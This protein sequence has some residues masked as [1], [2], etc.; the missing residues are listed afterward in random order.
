MQ[1]QVYVT[2][3]LVCVA[4]CMLAVCMLL[5]VHAINYDGVMLYNAAVID[6][7]LLHDTLAIA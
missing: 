5:R 3:I 7:D 6:Y 4:Q 2:Q 1:L